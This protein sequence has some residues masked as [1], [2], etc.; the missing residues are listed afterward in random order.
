[1]DSYCLNRKEYCEFFNHYL[2][3]EPIVDGSF[4]EKIERAT[5]YW[6]LN[7]I[8]SNCFLSMIFE[9]IMKKEKVSLEDIESIYALTNKFYF[10]IDQLEIGLI[11]DLFRNHMPEQRN[12][13]INE[14]IEAKRNN[15]FVRVKSIENDLQKTFEKDLINVLE[16]YY[17]RQN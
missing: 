13:A 3:K 9:N 8:G 4:L 2:G 16:K 17:A 6:D 15:D 10:T 5:F 12:E 14:L 7:L 11:D 1:M